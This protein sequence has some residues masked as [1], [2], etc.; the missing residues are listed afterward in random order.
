MDKAINHQVILARRPEGAPCEDAGRRDNNV[1][2]SRGIRKQ[3][4]VLPHYQDQMLR[5]ENDGKQLV[6][7]TSV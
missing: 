3:G 5:G 4:F 7:L 1:I 2:L 6:R